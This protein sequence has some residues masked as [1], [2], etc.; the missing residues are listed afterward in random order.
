MQCYENSTEYIPGPSEV[1]VFEK[2]TLSLQLQGFSSPFENTIEE[3]GW[4][5]TP[6]NKMEV[7]DCE[8]A[9]T[10]VV[11]LTVKIIHAGDQEVCG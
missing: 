8:R 3:C 5:M 2:E 11:M 6:L 9:L 7:R 10:P 4:R 1:G